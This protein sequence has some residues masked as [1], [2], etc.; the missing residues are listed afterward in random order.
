MK[1]V[2]IKSFVDRLIR[3]EDEL[4][5]IIDHELLAELQEALK[6]NDFQNNLLV[7]ARTTLPS[8]ERPK[9]DDIRIVDGIYYKWTSPGV[10]KQCCANQDG[11]LCDKLA[12]CGL[13]HAGYWV[14][15][16]GDVK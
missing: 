4:G 8:T 7:T 2:K 9:Q 12:L 3:L 15:V 10:C 1:F 16:E 14:R 11:Q 6:V 5:V 13:A